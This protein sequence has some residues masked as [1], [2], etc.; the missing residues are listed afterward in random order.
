MEI[1]S[2]FS[3]WWSFAAFAL[4]TLISLWYYKIKSNK[5]L[6][7]LTLRLLAFFIISILIAN[8]FSISRVEEELVPKIVVLH[9]NS[10]SI[11][12][13]ESTLA[14]QQISEFSSSVNNKEIVFKAFSDGLGNS[15]RN[16]TDI[17]GSLTSI[18]QREKDRLESIVLIS[19]GISNKGINPL[20][21]K[22][23]YTV[24]I[25]VIALGDSTEKQDV[26]IEVLKYPKEAS[27]EANIPIDI[28]V[29]GPKT[30]KSI[31]ATF[32]FEGKQQTKEINLKSGIG[33]WDIEQF[34]NP[35][36]KDY[37]KG[38][39]KLKGVPKEYNTLNNSQIIYIKNKK[40]EYNV[41]LVYDA[42]HPDIGVW[43]RALAQLKNTSVNLISLENYKPKTKNPNSL[44]ILFA[45][46]AQTKL[47]STFDI[48]IVGN[49]K[50]RTGTFEK[51][52]IEFNSA[53]VNSNVTPR[54]E[55]FDNLFSVGNVAALNALEYKS[56]PM[57]FGV[58]T[59]EAEHQNII[60]QNTDGLE[61]SFPLLATYTLNSKKKAVFFGEGLWQ[62]AT[63]YHLLSDAS[64]GVSYEKVLSNM[65]MY[66]LKSSGQERLEIFEPSNKLANEAHAWSVN[67]LNQSNEKISGAN[68][69]L[70]ITNEKGNVV[71]EYILSENNK[72]Y[73]TEVSG[74]ESGI[75]SFEFLAQYNGKTITKTQKVLVNDVGI[76]LLNK[77]AKFSLLRALSNE[78]EG[79]FFVGKTLIVNQ[80]EDILNSD[81]PTTVVYKN[82]KKYWADY[83]GI[84]LT[85]LVLLS[86]E[87]LVRR[88]NG[89]I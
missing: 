49:A 84:W 81:I 72:A 86:T 45:Y 28:V 12:S 82:E 18:I 46:K 51:L 88:R 60:S 9:D 83:W 7:L 50:L 71:S 36:E 25:H 75:Y 30:L 80:L 73:Q 68:I 57:P 87:W 21:Q 70:T 74:L 15:N 27:A 2:D 85:V 76:E 63:A 20:Y 31:E 5:R 40:S 38:E 43:Q 77:Q 6:P 16:E 8:P 1:Q 23:S 11:D 62:F 67:F 14:L 42:P 52:P 79:Q 22:E 13:T 4:S 33:R 56:S 17:A 29:S 44:S 32:T 61:N 53:N 55:E 34:F 48:H 47:T 54:F 69:S 10:L 3:F 37:L 65:S 66:L 89:L 24:P 59:V 41:T 78:T 64:N 35:K 58:L 19:D 26:K 39:L